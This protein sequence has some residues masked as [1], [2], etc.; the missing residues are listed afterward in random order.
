MEQIQEIVR[1][2]KEKGLAIASTK[3]VRQE[4]KY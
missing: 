4:G 3:K 1:I 2:R